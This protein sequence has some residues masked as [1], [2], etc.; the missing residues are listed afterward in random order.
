VYPTF[1]KT[2]VNVVVKAGTTARLDCAASG[3][4]IPEIAL[5]KDGGDD[6]PAARE[7]RMHILPS[8][9]MF[10]ILDVKMEDQG[11]YTCMA[12]NVVGVI[13]ANATLLVLG[14]NCDG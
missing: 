11:V 1:I 13:A 6:F 14:K 5:Q 3:H 8:D 10:F 12:K 4:P 7:R 2:P 9:E